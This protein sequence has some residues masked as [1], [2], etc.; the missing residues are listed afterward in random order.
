M[1]RQEKHIV[2]ITDEGYAMPTVI[3]IM[4]LIMSNSSDSYYDVWILGKGLSK[5]T[6]ETIESVGDDYVVCN[7][8]E[9]S[10]GKYERLAKSCL[11]EGIHVTDTALYKFDIANI[12]DFVDRVLYLDSD[13]LVYQDISELFGIE[14]SH[15]YLAAVDEMG[16]EMDADGNS[17]LA[18]RI[19]LKGVSYFNSGVMFF[20]LRQLRQE[21]VEEKL[22]EYRTTSPNYFMDQ[23]AFN[24]VM[25]AKRVRLPYYYNFRTA[26]FDVM[27][28]EKIGE[29]FYSVQYM[30]VQDCLSDQKIIHMSSQFKPWK[31]N[32]PWI[33]E[34]FLK[35]YSISPYK[36]E[37]LQLISPLKGLYDIYHPWK[38]EAERE[39]EALALKYQK[40]AS[41]RNQKIWGFP[42]KAIRHGSRVVLYGAGDMGKDYR[43]QIEATGY[44]S[45][46]LWVDKNYKQI[47]EKVKAP[48]KIEHVEF[49]Y[50]LVAIADDKIAREVKEYLKKLRIAEEQIVVL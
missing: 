20:N 25:Y 38:V 50:I 43:M 16:D 40:V 45:L 15:H 49:D 35:Y 36:D 30:T 41:E 21:R 14:L 44:C 5:K 17:V 34:L 3:S 42:Y 31:Y 18:S 23:D 48:E 8:I 33:T 24:S 9:V 26:L 22:L 27:L 37:K 2:Y 1:D 29:T 28:P 19:G 4:S 6:K 13:I 39:F 46:V 11:T 47:K 7:V 10:Q 12:L 32:I